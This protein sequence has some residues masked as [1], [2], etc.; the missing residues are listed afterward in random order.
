MQINK[1]GKLNKKTLLIIKL[2]KKN[3]INK[4]SLRSLNYYHLFFNF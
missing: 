4:S 3:Y 2:F 1:K